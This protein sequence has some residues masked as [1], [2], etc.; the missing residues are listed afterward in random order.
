[1]MVDGKAAEVAEHSGALQSNRAGR[2][3]GCWEGC[4]RRSDASLKPSHS[5]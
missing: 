2:K 3:T 1:M 4:S 5:S